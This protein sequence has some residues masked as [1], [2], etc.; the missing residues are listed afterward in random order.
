M[1]TLAAENVKKLL[2]SFKNNKGEYITLQHTI[3]LKKMEFT[4]KNLSFKDEAL[5]L[6]E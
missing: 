6:I 1:E 5:N 2:M 3:Y 4:T